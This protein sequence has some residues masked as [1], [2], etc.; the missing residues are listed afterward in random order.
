MKFLLIATCLLCIAASTRAQETTASVTDLPDSTTPDSTIGQQST[1]ASPSSTDAPMTSTPVAIS[2]TTTE[3]STMPS[4]DQYCYNGG[5][6]SCSCPPGF[7]GQR[8]ESL[9]D[10]CNATSVYED[11]METSVSLCG[12]HG[13]CHFDQS[14]GSYCECDQGWTGKFC[15]TPIPDQVLIST[16]CHFNYGAANPNPDCKDGFRCL[17]D[18]LNCGFVACS[19]PD[20]IGWCLPIPTHQKI[21]AAF[22]KIQ[23]NRFRL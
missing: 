7:T 1:E 11:G 9:V 15:D 17:P 6:A 21:M 18:K 5:T 8:C 22:M 4:D 19:S 12:P 16:R 3:Q 23:S 14:N 20:N 2:T 10:W 13:I